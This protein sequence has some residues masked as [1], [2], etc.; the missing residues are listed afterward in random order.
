MDLGAHRIMGIEHLLRGSLCENCEYSESRERDQALR[1]AHWA[2]F[3]RAFF[4]RR[5]MRDLCFG[6]NL[7]AV[8]ADFFA[9]GASVCRCGKTDSAAAT[10]F[11]AIP[12]IAMAAVFSAESFGVFGIFVPQRS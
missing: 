1:K 9:G 8:L 6:G 10:A 11:P 3:A 5:G 4:W 7:P 2:R 12:P